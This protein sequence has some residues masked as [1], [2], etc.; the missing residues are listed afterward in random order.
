[1][2]APERQLELGAGPFRNRG[3]FA[4]HFLLERLREW[5]EFDQ[6][7]SSS[8]YAR[9]RS[10]WRDEREELGAANEA[11]TEE[12]WVRP[13]LSALGFH[14]T[15]QAPLHVGT[16]LRQPDYGLFLS[17]AD[18]RAATGLEGADRFARAACIADA[19][20]F[21]RPL[22][23]RRAEGA[24][25]EDPV[26]QI[27][28]YVSATRCPWG[29]LT[30]GRHWRLYAAERN[31]LGG[32]H[33]EV[34]LVAL[35]EAQD[36]DAFR[37]FAVF[38]SAAAFAPGTDGRPLL[39]RILAESRAA[40]VTV[41]AALERQVFVAVPSIAEGFLGPATATPS[42]LSDAFDNALVLLY[43]LLF[44]LH[45]EARGLLPVDNPHY[46]E[47]SL[48]RQKERLA[49]DL[50]RGRR[51]SGRSDDL[52]NDL[53]ALFR[54]VDEGDDDL[55]VPEYDGGLF[56]AA[57][58]P[59]SRAARCLTICSPRPSTRSTGSEEVSSTTVTS[60]LATSGR[61]TSDCSTTASRT[62]PVRS[63]SRQLRV[64][65]IPAPTS[66]PS[67]SSIASSSGPSRRCS[68]SVRATSRHSA[69][70]ARRR[71]RSS[72]ASGCWTRR[73]AAATS[74]SPRRPGS[75]CTSPP[76]RP[77]TAS[78]RSRRYN[79]GWPSTACTGSIST[80]WRSSS[81][82]SRCGSVRCAAASRSPF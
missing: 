30:N 55:G 38:F 57:R 11:Q 60:R 5:P 18:R 36:E 67:A 68:T 31:L 2:S 42:A 63:A 58:H 45:A 17:D 81:L 56:S 72:S 75:R 25:S 7:D 26:A 76:T 40:A 32:A 43:R 29:I 35:L 27:I 47:Y 34:D 28:T 79:A 6:A 52:Y 78:C 77:T 10:L 20:R 61:S 50:D 15:V 74:W 82:S 53:R 51:F 66:H 39:E 59:C 65:A 4:D 80:P 8:L 73:W 41:G 19:K 22:D 54:I 37:W 49:E 23:R 9:L 48:R 69:C 16:R 12:R 3:L 44:C 71:S 14:Y 21:A 33:Y 1:M 24:L 62:P 64:D 70:A 13:V 46:L